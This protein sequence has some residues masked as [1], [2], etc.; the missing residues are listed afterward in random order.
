[1]LKKK[2]PPSPCCWLHFNFF[3]MVVRA[4]GESSDA[5]LPLIFTS[6]LNVGAPMFEIRLR[7][8]RRTVTMDM[9]ADT[10]VGSLRTDLCP[11]FF[12]HLSSA[13]C[14]RNLRPSSSDY[15]IL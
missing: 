2:N 8:D 5:P 10:S 15:S 1:M 12:I 7:I 4:G 14:L 13:L 9:N 3:H 6:V 11:Y